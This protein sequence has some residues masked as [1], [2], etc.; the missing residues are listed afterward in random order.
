LMCDLLGVDVYEVIDAAATK[1]FGFS[2]FYPGPGLGGHCIPIDP[3]YLAWKLKALNFQ[4]RF[5]GLAAEINGM[6]PTVVNSMVAD[7]LNQHS[8]SIRGS[9]IMIL[10]VAYKKNVSDCRE[11]PALD[12]MR[13]LSQKG[14]VLSYNDPFVPSM[15]LNGE[16]LR[17]V[18]L[19]PESIA[20]QDCLIILTDHSIYDF[21]AI[22]ASAILV[23]DTRNATKGFDE[24][25]DRIIKLGAGNKNAVA[26]HHEDEHDMGGAN[27]LRH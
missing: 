24:F 25:K 16:V 3:H 2:P 9:K 4:A 19:S 21:K 13:L 18:E 5:I 26:G 22:I 20:N 12:V 7:G 1:P 15:R 23:I 8:K 14:A 17:S 11:S 27:Y 10:G 6:M